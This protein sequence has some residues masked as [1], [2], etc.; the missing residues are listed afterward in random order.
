MDKEKKVW[1]KPQLIILERGKPEEA[2]LANC[3]TGGA[4]IGPN[5][6]QCTKSDRKC[7][8]PANS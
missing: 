8:T 7:N 2:I 5:S 1:V 6:E 4:P 3:K